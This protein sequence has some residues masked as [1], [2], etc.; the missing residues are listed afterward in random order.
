MQRTR[1]KVRN[2]WLKVAEWSVVV[3]SCCI[4]GGESRG[5]CS[6]FS[7]DDRVAG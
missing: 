7:S 5:T 3:R 1:E 2:T 4:P 6:R